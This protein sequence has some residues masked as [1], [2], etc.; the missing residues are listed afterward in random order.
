[1][2][3]RNYQRLDHAE[4][5]ALQRQH[6]QHVQ[7]CQQHADEESNPKA[8]FFF[9]RGWQNPK[10]RR[11]RKRDGNFARTTEQFRAAGIVLADACARSRPGHPSLAESA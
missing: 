5:P 4:S 2:N 3:Q 11:G 7:T 10:L 9:Q 1:M 8:I 6:Q